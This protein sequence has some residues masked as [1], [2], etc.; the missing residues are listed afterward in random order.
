MRRAQSVREKI[1]VCGEKY[2]QQRFPD[3]KL[4]QKTRDCKA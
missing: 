3:S 1:M 4:R 2:L